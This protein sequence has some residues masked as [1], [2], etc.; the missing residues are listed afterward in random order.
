VVSFLADVDDV[1]GIDR[2]ARGRASVDHVELGALAPGE[3]R[4]DEP[5]LALVHLQ[6]QPAPPLVAQLQRAGLVHSDAGGQRELDRRVL[7]RQLPR[8]DRD[9]GPR[10]LG[11]G[12]CCGRHRHRQHQG[13]AAGNSE[14]S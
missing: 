6:R 1:T 13:Q 12:R 7:P 9:R 8:F 3:R 11:R 4:Q 10:G 14:L 2:G 5:R